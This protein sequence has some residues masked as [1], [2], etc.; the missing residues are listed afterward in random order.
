M[1]FARFVVSK[2]VFFFS[3]H[4][5]GPILSFVFLFAVLGAV[6]FAELLSALKRSLARIL[7]LIVS[8]GYGIVK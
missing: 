1:D 3:F 4:I 7:V 8:L 5:F 6:I 2:D